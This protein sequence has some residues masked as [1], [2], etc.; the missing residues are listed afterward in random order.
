MR[1]LCKKCKISTKEI[2]DSYKT[3][4]KQLK[5]AKI[6]SSDN[7]NT[8]N[9]AR[10]DERVNSQ[11]IIASDSETSL[12]KLKQA[13]VGEDL[14]MNGVADDSDYDLQ[15]DMG[16]IG[17]ILFD[18]FIAPIETV[19]YKL[20]TSYA[21]SASKGSTNGDTNASEKEKLM[22]LLQ[23]SLTQSW[24]INT[25]VI[26]NG[27][28]HPTGTTQNNTTQKP[29]TANKKTSDTKIDDPA[30]QSF[31]QKNALAQKA[32][33][34]QAWI[35]GNI[36]REGVSAWP[37]A[38]TDEEKETNAKDVDTY[39]A[40]IQNQIDTYD[41]LY[42][43]DKNIPNIANNPALSGMTTDQA[44]QFV[45]QYI[46]DLFNTGSTNSCLKSCDSLPVADRVV[47]Q[48]Q[49][50]CFTMSRP[51]NPDARVKSMNDMLKLR[52]CM[53]PAKSMAIPRGRD[54]Y[55]LDTI[56][57]RIQANMDNVINGGE[58]VKFQK[59]K[60]FLEN[61]IADFSFAK[62]FSFQINLNM[63][64]I[65]NNKSA[66][67]KKDQKETYLQKLE[68]ANWKEATLG[69]DPNKYI[70][71]ADP[72]RNKIN[73][74]CAAELQTCQERYDAQIVLDQLKSRKNIPTETANITITEKKSEMLTIIVD[75]LRE[76]NKF[77]EQTEKELQNLNNIV[78]SLQSKL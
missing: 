20:P 8:I 23:N 47:C 36:C 15:V 74:E 77:W 66:M 69:V 70:I 13:T 10:V 50:L 25:S 34:Q 41:N 28:S 40:T 1:F 78:S 2:T 62:L 44:N 6:I 22:E 61:P 37:S 32:T 43:E 3:I 42:P 71:V 33:T 26:T 14:F 21:G 29:T 27:W 35:E 4:L 59:T 73:K 48:I 51:N 45:E 53:I 64:P 5:E 31:V 65:F 75:F 57:T 7:D 24:S 58:M 52:F 30:L 49:C 55:S 38:P 12:T 16:N 76:N 68:K 67:A 17:N 46:S 60:E 19:F 56:L 72:T 18:S 11:F 39:L 54:I 63:K 9:R